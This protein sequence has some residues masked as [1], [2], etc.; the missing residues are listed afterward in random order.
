MPTCMDDMVYNNALYWLSSIPHH[1]IRSIPPQTQRTPTS[2]DNDQHPT[3][4]VVPGE[5]ANLPV[6]S[7]RNNKHT[8]HLENSQEACLSHRYLVYGLGTR[9]MLGCRRY[10]RIVNNR[11]F[12]GCR[13]CQVHHN[14][15]HNN[16]P[17]TSR[18]RGKFRSHHRN[19]W[20]HNHSIPIQ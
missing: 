16:T 6:T 7:H 11:T 12:W 14:H 19:R 3:H 4:K 1:K 9:H 10:L 17:H 20:V 18:S 13:C 2:I 5:N 8:H 15:S